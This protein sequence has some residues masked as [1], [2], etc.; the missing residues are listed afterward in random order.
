LPEKKTSLEEVE[1]FYDDVS[2]EKDSIEQDIMDNTML[3]NE[4][5]KEIDLA[6]DNNGRQ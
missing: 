1:G 5:I 3:P 4:Q 6:Q 2:K